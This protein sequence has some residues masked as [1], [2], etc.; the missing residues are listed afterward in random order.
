MQLIYPTQLLSPFGYGIYYFKQGYIPWEQNP[1][2]HGTSN[3]DPQGPYMKYLG[4]KQDC[5]APIDDFEVI[6]DAQPNIPLVINIDA[7]LDATTYAAIHSAGP[8]NYIP[9]QFQEYYSVKTK[10][11][12]TIYDSSDNII[13]EQAKEVLIPY[14]GSTRIEF[15]WTP[16]IA[17]NYKA[18]AETD[19]TDEKCLSSL[20]QSTS[21]EFTVLSSQPQNSC[22]TL[23]NNLALSDQFPEDGKT[24]TISATK[25]SNYADNNYNLQPVQT[26]VTLTITKD[27]TIIKQESEIISS[28]SNNF[29]PQPFDFDWSIDSGPGNYNV[30]ISGIAYS[31][32]CNGL[33]NLR[34]TISLNSYVT[35][36]PNNA[37]ALDGIPDKTINENEEPEDNWIDLFS[38]AT[39]DQPDEELTFTVV[40]QSNSALIDCKINDDR[41]VDCQKPALNLYGYSDITIEISDG[42]YSDRDTFK[43]NVLPVNYPPYLNFIGNKQIN[44]NQLL[45]FTITASDPDSDPLTYSASSLPSGATFSSQTFTWTPDYAQSGSYQVTFSATDGAAA[46]SETITIAVGNSNRMPIITSIP[47]LNATEGE[48]YTYQIIASDL[49]NESLQYSLSGAPSNMTINSSTGLIT[50]TPTYNEARVKTNSVAIIVSDGIDS[51]IQEYDI[52]MKYLL[53]KSHKF[54]LD[55]TPTTDAQSLS[56]GEDYIS[57]IKLSNK[58]QLPEEDIEVSVSVPELNINFIAE[59]NIYLGPHDIKYAEINFNIPKAALPGEYLIRVNV[60]NNNYKAIGYST[61]EIKESKKDRYILLLP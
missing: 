42:Q 3:N 13:D 49:D 33:E 5:Y 48:E 59:Q 27:S 4:K 1:N 22:Y 38:Y 56:Q 29:D 40:S 55:I 32:L 20:E 6:N 54:S 18:T 39:D 46:D 26:D 53:H 15:T 47:Q 28:N 9:E 19:V 30:E 21:K 60:E 37:P 51:V 7:S 16:T 41:Y 61:M 10:V 50:W 14:S 43:V 31:P 35:S 52:S 45:T 25:I 58:G 57:Y 8:L 11:T 2:W 24:V 17:G 34:E 36:R 23:L 12:L 44:E